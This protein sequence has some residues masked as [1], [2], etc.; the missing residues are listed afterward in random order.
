MPTRHLAINPLCNCAAATCM[1]KM[2]DP[3]V[4][5]PCNPMTTII[6]VLRRHPA[7]EYQCSAQGGEG[8]FDPNTSV[9][10]TP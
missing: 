9:Y 5:V 1:I 3:V 2:T 7:H 8:K 10:T 4:V 6:C